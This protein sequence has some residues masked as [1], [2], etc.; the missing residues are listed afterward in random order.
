TDVANK[1]FS[2]LYAEYKES[3]DKGLVNEQKEEDVQAD[4]IGCLFT[5]N[6][7]RFESGRSARAYDEEKE[8]K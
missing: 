5:A 8:A 1:S 3:Q 7:K 6:R 4:L 2:Q